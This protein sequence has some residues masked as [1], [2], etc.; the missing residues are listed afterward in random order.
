MWL[1]KAN[2]SINVNNDIFSLE[3]ITDQ[4]MGLIQWGCGSHAPSVPTI[5][6]M[7]FSKEISDII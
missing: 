6:N 3:E 2:G 1:K 7:K 5:E 4:S